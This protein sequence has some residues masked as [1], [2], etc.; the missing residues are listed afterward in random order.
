MEYVLDGWSFCK[1]NGFMRLLYN[2]YFP[3]L[4]FLFLTYLK[5][6]CIFFAPA[7]HIFLNEQKAG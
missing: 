2:R 7:S 3:F 1:V 6:W 5:I 4:A